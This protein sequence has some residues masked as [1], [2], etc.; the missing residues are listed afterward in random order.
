M[1]KIDTLIEQ[2]IQEAVSTAKQLPRDVI[3]DLINV[4]YPYY[5]STDRNYKGYPEKF[6]LKDIEDEAKSMMTYYRAASKGKYGKENVDWSKSQLRIIEELRLVYIL[7]YGNGD[8]ACYSLKDGKVYDDNHELGKFNHMA[9]KEDQKYN[10][11]VY[12]VEPYKKWRI[13]I[14]NGKHQYAW[15]DK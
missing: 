2:Y 8:H 15:K 11:G 5:Y 13:G 10:Y 12:P 4:I 7:S 14:L 3:Q 9:T 1:D 6:T